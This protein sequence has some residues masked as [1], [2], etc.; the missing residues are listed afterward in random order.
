MSDWARSP[1]RL[2]FLFVLRMAITYNSGD[3]RGECMMK[4]REM[5]LLYHFTDQEKAGKIKAVLAR[6]KI[7]TKDISD[8]LISQKVGF[9][10]GLKGFKETVGTSEAVS[11][12]QEVMLMRGIT[13]KRM[14]E[15]LAN[16]TAAGIEKIGL[17][18]VVT[19]YNVL[20]PLHH[21]CKTIQKERENM[22]AKMKPE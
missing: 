20:W 7:E 2:F 14:E 13:G 19:P 17:K 8:A 11:F 1:S 3:I 5:V 18:A 6:M 16:F 4:I 9:L 21:L 22:Q 15:I 12:D 10:L